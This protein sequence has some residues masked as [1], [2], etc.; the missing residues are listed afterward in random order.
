VGTLV[1]WLVATRSEIPRISIAAANANTNMAYVALEGRC[2]RGPRYD[3][4]DGTLSFWIDDGTGEAH[5]TAYRAEVEPLIAAGRVPALGDRITVAGTL[6]VREDYLGLTLNAPEHLHIERPHPVS[7]EIGALPAA[8]AYERVRVQGQ[9]R[10]I[11]RPYEGLTLVTLRDATG[12]VPLALSR[13]LRALSASSPTLAAGQSVV[14]S[15]TVSHYRGAPQLVPATLGDVTP[16]AEEVPIAAARTIGALQDADVGRLVQ[17]QGAVS[18]PTPFSAGTKLTLDDGTGRIPVVLWDA[19]AGAVADATALRSGAHVRVRGRLS[20]YRGQL[21]L[22]PELGA[23]VQLLVAPLPPQPVTVAT[24]GAAD[25]GRRVRIEG[26]LGPPHPFSAGVTFPLDDG[27]GPIT[28]LLWDDLHRQLPHALEAGH[29]VA[30]AGEVTE[31]RGALEIVPQAVEDVH[32]LDGPT[33]PPAP[34]PTPR[35]LTPIGE[36]DSG[37]VGRT[38]TVAGTLGAWERFSGGVK[39]DL[40]DASGAIT[41]LLWEE[42]YDALDTSALAPGTSLTVTGRIEVYR[43]ALEIIPDLAGMRIA[44]PAR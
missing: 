7:R 41:L 36:I 42:V 28:L 18:D 2:I 40:Q 4:E 17:L 16:L 26:L 44:S 25:V 37:D 19:V 20:R 21:E 8:G 24:L 5:V 10:T 9:I 35:P 6:R 31:Y 29:R 14:V 11:E 1:L 43:G 3:P 27:T 33:P 38:H 23:D 15:A 34:A 12:V 13:D 30:V 32:I 39:A 22:I